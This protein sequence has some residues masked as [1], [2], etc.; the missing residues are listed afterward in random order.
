MSP[1]KNGGITIGPDA[2]LL[3]MG[4][5]TVDGSNNHL[6]PGQ[7]LVGAAD[8]VFPRLLTPHYVNNTGTAP[9]TLG[10]PGSGAPTVSNTN[11]DPTIAPG[12]NAT[13]AN[14]HSVVDANP[15]IISNLIVDQTLNN[16]SA[17]VSALL[18]LSGGANVGDIVAATA[19]ADAILAARAVA[20]A[21]APT[22]V[23]T[24]AAYAAS[25][26]FAV[27]VKTEVNSALA[28]LTSLHADV[29]ADG[30]VN[31]PVDDAAAAVTAANAALS[32]ATAMLNALQAPGA[33]VAIADLTNA[34]AQVSSLTSFRDAVVAVQA[35]LL[36]GATPRSA[37]AQPRPRPRAGRSGPERRPRTNLRHD[38]CRRRKAVHKLDRFLPELEAPAVGYQF[39]C[40]VWHACLD[41]R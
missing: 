26:P 27:T 24:D 39:H 15:R 41:H 20:A 33:T 5:R 6:L 37:D 10:P 34:I 23:A 3:P 22:A 35:S 9:I 28:S 4:L 7:S 36:D 13:G 25:L 31:N 32:A 16:R 19:D 21:A 17:L 30:L 14:N 38:G 40:G 12:T 11:Y 2:A 8:Q 1:V 18:V 29:G